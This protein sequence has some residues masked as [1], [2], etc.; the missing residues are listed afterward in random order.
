[1]KKSN[2]KGKNK[3]LD[4]IM[5]DPMME[6]LAENEALFRRLAP[7]NK[8]ENK[9][10]LLAKLIFEK[11]KS[12]QS[13]MSEIDELRAKKRERDLEG[14]V[15]GAVIKNNPRRQEE[16][17]YNWCEDFFCH[18]TNRLCELK[19]SIAYNLEWLKAARKMITT[20]RYRNIPE[21]AFEY[22]KWDGDG[23]VFWTDDMSMPESC[24]KDCDC[25]EIN[26]GGLPY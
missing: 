24:G 20:K 8:Q 19:D 10:L 1:M 23:H 17:K 26:P 4:K 2:S 22:L 11:E 6:I 7:K 9:E 13:Q 14:E 21:N 16:W 3:V 25:L 5:A 12:L 15:F 18:E